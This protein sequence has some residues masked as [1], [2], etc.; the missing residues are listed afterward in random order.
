MGLYTVP[1]EFEDRLQERFGGKFR[2]RWS[3]QNSEW[4]LEQRVRRSHAPVQ[5][6]GWR[7]DVIRYNDGFAWIMSWK[8][9]S[10]FA[11]PKCAYTLTAPTRSTRMVVCQPCQL[12]GYDHQWLA[13]HWPMDDTLI[14]YIEKMDK[15]IDGQRDDLIRQQAA[16]EKQQLRKVLDPTLDAIADNFNLGMGIQSVGYTGKVFK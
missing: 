5:E 3:D 1:T 14:E 8:Q 2:V 9:G 16:L 15:M 11:C 6:G 4:Q 7:D 12:K 10:K 13:G